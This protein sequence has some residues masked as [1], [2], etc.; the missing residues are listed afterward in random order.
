MQGLRGSFEC[1]QDICVYLCVSN[2]HSMAPSYHFAII[3]RPIQISTAPPS[4][5]HPHS[6]THNVSVTGRSLSLKHHHTTSVITQE[7]V[8]EI[9][10]VCLA[11]HIS[12][13]L[14]L[15]V[16]PFL[17]LICSFFPLDSCFLVRLSQKSV[18]GN[19]LKPIIGFRCT[20][21]FF[22]PL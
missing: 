4:T 3:N 19:D 8:G 13:S 6:H 11:L 12:I 15:S 20:H 22:P 1:E 16:P 14:Q 2:L 7:I 5:P 9:E 17:L 18:K 21:S 10:K